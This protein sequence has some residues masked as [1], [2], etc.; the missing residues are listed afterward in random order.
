MVYGAC[1][2]GRNVNGIKM[3]GKLVNNTSSKGFFSGSK[4]HYCVTLC[5]IHLQTCIFSLMSKFLVISR[6]A[7]RGLV[8]FSDYPCLGK[9]FKFLLLRLFG[10]NY[11]FLIQNGIFE[12]RNQSAVREEG[13][14]SL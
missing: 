14:C 10:F 12:Y 11:L 6:D 8:Q 13:C 4:F 9:T 2:I 7:T 1:I 5:R 3:Q